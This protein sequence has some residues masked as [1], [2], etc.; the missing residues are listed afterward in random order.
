MG[1]RLAEEVISLIKPLVLQ[2]FLLPCLID[3]S[4]LYVCSFTFHEFYVG[5][6]F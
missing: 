2:F 6:M 3:F 4:R 1:E 5:R